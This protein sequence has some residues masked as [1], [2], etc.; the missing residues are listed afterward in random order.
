METAAALISL[1]VAFIVLGRFMQGGRRTDLLLAAALAILGFTNLFFAAL[2]VA[3]GDGFTHWATWAA[4]GG[5]LLGAFA[6]AAAAVSQERIVRNPRASLAP[7]L[8]GVLSALGVIALAAAFVADSLPLGI[9][10]SMSPMA[11]GTRLIE[12]QSGVL[13]LQVVTFVFC[14]IATV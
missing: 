14:S 5:R 3:V 6:F 12:G 13:A 9:D 10:P 1:L 11:S 2:P 8:V 7:L 4:V